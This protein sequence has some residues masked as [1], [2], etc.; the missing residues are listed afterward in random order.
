M[1]SMALAVPLLAI[2]FAPD[3]VQVEPNPILPLGWTVVGPSPA[4]LRIQ[5][6]F[7]IK[8]QNIEQLHKLLMEVSTPNSAS[9]GKHLSNDKVHALIAPDGGDISAVRHFLSSHN[10]KTVADAS[11]NSDLLV[12][13]MSVT[14]AEALLGGVRYMQLRH[15]AS[16]KLIHR[17][18]EPYHLPGRVAAALDF[19]SPTVHIPGVSKMQ[20]LPVSMASSESINIPATL[21]QLYSVGFNVTGKAPDNK[22]AV[23]AFLGQYYSKTDLNAFWSKYCTAGEYSKVDLTC[24]K[25]SP[26]L[27][28]DAT[29]GT[30]GVESMLD[31]ETITGVA[32]NIESEFWGYSGNSPDN[33]E[34]EPYMKWLSAVSTTPD[35]EIPKLFSTSYGEDESSWSFPAASRLNTEFMKAGARGI[36]LLY[37]SGD[38]GSNCKSGKFV[39]EGPGSSPYVTAVGGTTPTAGFPSPG[40]ESAASLSSGGFSSYWAQPS[41]QKAAVSAYLSS[42]TNLPPLSRG[43]NV[44]G[45]A[46]PDISAQAT[47]FCVTPFGCDIAGTSCATPTASGIFSLLNDLRLQQGKPTLG[48]LNP[49]IYQNAA[50]FNDITTGSSSG[51]LFGNGWPATAGWDAVTGVGTPNYEKL[52]A[53]VASLN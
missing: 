25:G 15:S 9:Y 24:G 3:R 8:Q 18:L 5:L 6:T 46:Y 49:L 4:D 16:G 34:N 43:Y 42:S 14:E 26:K 7:A 35:E 22:Q 33:P 41:Y 36:S 17:I 19:I 39:P 11:P 27:V 10:I 47:N 2:G 28:G 30:A 31:I 37:A 45:R 51:C 44:S 13:T 20:Q 48:F 53:V 32:G 1:L 21:R 52:A 23:T 29:T 40:S 50:A 38:E 12:A